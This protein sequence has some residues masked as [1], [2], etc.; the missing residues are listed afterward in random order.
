[1]ANHLNDLSRDDPDL[2]VDTARRWLGDPT[3]TTTALVRHGL[4]TLVKRGNVGAL[5]LLGF[6]P[7]SVD[8]DGP[9]IVAARVPWSGTV[10]FTAALRNTGTEPARLAI[11]YVIHHRKANGASSTKVFKLTTREL[12]PGEQFTIDR[13]HSFRPITTRRYYPGEHAVASRSTASRRPRPPSNCSRKTGFPHGERCC[14]GQPASTSQRS[15]HLRRSTRIG[16]FHQG[17][18]LVGGPRV[19]RPVVHR[20]VGT[21]RH[22]KRMCKTCCGDPATAVRHR[23]HL[24]IENTR[25]LEHCTQLV[26]RFRRPVAGSTRSPNGMLMLPGM[27]PR[28]GYDGLSPR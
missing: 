14:R 6:A 11:D 5:A 2:V 1:M 7:A 21:P 17:Q 25:L 3:D 18:R 4:R 24:R 23:V 19:Q 9:H 16:A 10:Q 13:E 27:W 12:D 26:G 20:N 15:R 28:R 22:R 8:V